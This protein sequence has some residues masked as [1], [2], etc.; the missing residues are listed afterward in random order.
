[1]TVLDERFTGRRLLKWAVQEQFYD[2]ITGEV[3]AVHSAVLV[4]GTANGHG[5][6]V[7]SADNWDTARDIFFT[8]VPEN[9]FQIY[10]GR[11]LYK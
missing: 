1:M 5:M 3:L 10:D 4:D 9:E 6:A 2:P 11:V 7:L 8:K